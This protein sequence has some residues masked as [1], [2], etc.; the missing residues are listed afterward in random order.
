MVKDVNYKIV[1]GKEEA[2]YL[3]ADRKDHEDSR[4]NQ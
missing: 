4:I 3:V 2:G 1:R